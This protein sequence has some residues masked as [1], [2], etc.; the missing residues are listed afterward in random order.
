MDWDQD[1][2]ND[3]NVLLTAKIDLIDLNKH[4]SRQDN[5]VKV[6]FPLVQLSPS[7]LKVQEKL[8]SAFF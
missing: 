2:T 1:D 5:N 4:N 8:W 3:S 7:A 6:S